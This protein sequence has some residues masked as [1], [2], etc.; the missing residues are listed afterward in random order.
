MATYACRPVEIMQDFGNG[1]TRVK[2]LDAD[3]PYRGKLTGENDAE[4]DARVKSH[5]ISDVSTE[6]IRWI[7]S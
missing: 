4:R 1:I 5:G 2:F 6:M 7:E 3:A